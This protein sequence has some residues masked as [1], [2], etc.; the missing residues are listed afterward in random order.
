[1]K[2]LISIS[3][4]DDSAKVYDSAYRDAMERISGQVPDQAEMAKQVLAFIVHARGP[5]TASVLQE[6]L[7][8]E[9]DERHFDVDNCPAVD[10]LI[11]ACA[12]LVTL[13]VGKGIIRL[14]QCT[15]REFFQ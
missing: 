2:S 7:G 15:A 11:S 10:D 4:T 12:G 3:K 13:N 5:L 1:L 14:V 9:V 6:A 8:I